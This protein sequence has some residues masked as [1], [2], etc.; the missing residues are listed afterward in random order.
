MASKGLDGLIAKGKSIAGKVWTI[1]LKAVDLVTAPFRK[2]WGLISNPITQAAAFAGISFGTADA[3]NTF[4]D[5]ESGMSQVSAVSGATGK[6]L[7]RLSEK[8][9]E[10]GKTTKFTSTEAAEA[11]N[12]MAMAGWKTDQMLGGIEGVMNLAAASGENLATVSDIMTDAMTAFGISAEGSTNGVSNA[13]HF[14]DVLAAAASNANTNVS[15]LGES[16]KYAAPVAGAMG[17]AAEDTAAALGLMANAGIKGSQGG[18]ALRGMLTSLVSPS[19][20]AAALMKQY[21]ISLKDG[22]GNMKSLGQ[23]MGDLRQNLG[24]LDEATQ[25]LVATEMFGQEAMSGVLAIV[26]ASEG[27]YRKLTSAI[28]N[29]DG[30]AKK[31]S[32]TMQDNL[33]GSLTRL[34]SAFSGVQETVGSKLAP[35]IRSLADWLT[36]H[37]P[38]IEQAVGGAI[39]FITGKIDAFMQRFREM[40]HSSEWEKAGSV[41]EKMKI[42]WDKLVAEPF[43]QWWNSKGKAWLTG[44]AQSVGSGLGTALKTGIL[45][46]LGIDF[47]GAAGEALENGMSIGR[48]FLQGFLDGFE[49]EKVMSA[50]RSALAGGI[51]AMASDAATLI[52]G[53]QKASGTS[54]I[55][56]AI[57]G[58]GALKAA[59]GAYS[60]YKGGRNLLGLAGHAGAGIMEGAQ[61]VVDAQGGSAAAQSALAMA[62]GGGLGTRALLGS[63]LAGLAGPGAASAGT[64]T[65]IGAGALA[66]GIVGGVTLISGGMDWIESDKAR[67][68]GDKQRSDAYLK[69][70]GFKMGGVAA[71]AA[72]GAAIGSVVPVV[73]TAAG[74]LIG[75]GV[76]G[77]AGWAAG[78]KAVNE[79]EEAVGE[80]E[81]AE[82]QLALKRS[83]LEAIGPT[84]GKMKM[85]AE[86]LAEALEDSSVSAAEFQAKFNDAVA[87]RI[88]DSFGTVKLSMQEIKDIA[89]GIVLKDGLGEK[90]E[91]LATASSKAEQSLSSFKASTQD[92]DKET[93][94]VSIKAG[95]K[96]TESEQ[97]SYKASAESFIKSAIE[98][99]E[100]KQYEATVAM[101]LIMGEDYDTSGLEGA[102]GGL[103]EQIAEK[104]QEL[105]SAIEAALKDGTVST[106]PVTLPDGSIQFS[107]AEEIANLRNQLTEIVNQLSQAESEAS[108]EALQ[109]KYGGA[110]LDA[111]SFSK[112]QSEL[113]EQMESTIASYDEALEITL[114]NLKIQYPD[115]GEEYDEAVKKAAEE[116]HG[117]I[118]A[119]NAEVE[120]FQ[121]DT[122]AGAFGSS[123]EEALETAKPELTGSVSENL[124]A[125]MDDAL[126]IEP[127]PAEWTSD[128]VIQ[129]FGL[130][131]LDEAV[132]AEAVAE[133]LKGV[134]QTVPEGIRKQ[135]EAEMD[136]MSLSAASDKLKSTLG[137]SLAEGIQGADL[138]GAY[139][140]ITTLRNLVESDAKAKFETAIDVTT[141]VNVTYDYHVTNP[142]PPKPNI[143]SGNV[144]V[145][146]VYG[147][148]EGGF[149]N[150]P[151]LSWVGEDGPEAIIPL[152]SK[153]RG[154]GLA[155]YEQV[156]EILGV[157][158]NAEG[159]IVG[160]PGG[161]AGK[162]GMAAFT[163]V[164]PSA[165]LSSMP[166]I[167]SRE[168][169]TAGPGEILCGQGNI[170]MR[171]NA[172]PAPWD[173][174]LEA[175]W[176]S[177]HSE[178][179]GLSAP[180]PLVRDDHS[181]ITSQGMPRQGPGANPQIRCGGWPAA[182]GIGS[183]K[184]WNDPDWDDSDLG[185]SG[186]SGLDW[187]D[188]DW[189]NSDWDVP[190]WDTPMW[191]PP[192]PNALTDIAPW[193]MPAEGPGA[194]I[195]GNRGALWAAPQGIPGGDGVPDPQDY[196]SVPAPWSFP[197]PD[198]S[199][200]QG[201]N[202]QSSL[203]WG[204]PLGTLP[205]AGQAFV[206]ESEAIAGGASDTT[207]ALFRPN[208]ASGVWNRNRDQNWDQN[209]DQDRIQNHEED[210]RR[211][212]WDAEGREAGTG[213]P[214]GPVT[215]E[216]LT[217][218]INVDGAGAQNPQELAETIREKVRGMTDEIA[219]QLA[220]ALKQTYANTPA[221][222]W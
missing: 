24:G 151:E 27:D 171:G 10:M 210:T 196:G 173:A 43:G 186:T 198:N 212:T 176:E 48:S 11:F 109:I 140:G 177:G 88:K 66:G 222:A 168:M 143:S 51:K 55:S 119:L 135:L 120:K 126:A 56:A 165:L 105:R 96:L 124:K 211:N 30:A 50:V 174:Q 197:T 41:W 94:K 115:G 134:A 80:A 191:K 148:A 1:T 180:A 205:W 74:A 90:L 53:G 172:A 22:E 61:L 91:A 122:V 201:A 45:G 70:G 36:A 15:M 111:E 131:Q 93:W 218:Q 175:Q 142:N 178:P 182:P 14:A 190:E 206:N 28:E 169:L 97:E 49:G 160:T 170:V 157:A 208:A 40:V 62:Q 21:G 156:G 113:Q 144:R 85:G 220:V 199:L 181:D 104:A 32:D 20:N 5:F 6:D 38:E 147:N 145:S 209:W 166:I 164:V 31:M 193:N 8:A 35:Y 195:S 214:R 75:A 153:R 63:R 59:S 185:D 204:Q 155:L 57:L 154:R 23:V 95:V 69:S 163:P 125:I 129:W 152:G 52:P 136:S 106:E 78:K 141:P 215:I 39:D 64:A 107:E 213:A 60:L 99:V 179:G 12:Y 16:F 77:I 26:N 110:N 3:V 158:K 108:M 25:T 92:L 221:A 58:T 65:A 42:A 81:K 9:R 149:I 34:Q 17:Y 188:G 29:A 150:R 87:Q 217:F 200:S 207:P 162:H 100:S 139:D 13:A 189:D 187:D 123:L 130:D 37:M 203:P 202:V 101:K 67:Q 159:G 146:E 102:Y 46:I 114:T 47:E 128:Q 79:Y 2:I 76:G 103:Q 132:D 117:K 82:A 18:T 4:M 192:V 71:G 33:K 118:D 183:G 184:P 98:Y 89:S 219:Y 83:K 216:N 121:L 194:G 73:G 84:L 138:S 86:G 68:A 161:E 44:V 137:V 127:D 116:Y 19:K 112:L 167:G 54:W 72:A 133:M 7:D